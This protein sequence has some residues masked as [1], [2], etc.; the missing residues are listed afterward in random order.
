LPLKEGALVHSIPHLY[1]MVDTTG[2]GK[3]DSRTIWYTA[4]GFKDTHGMASAFTWGFDGWIYGCHGFSNTSTLQGLDGRPIRLT[5]GN[6]YR[7]RADGRHIESYSY[8]QVNP[9][10]LA[11][12][13][14]GN[15][16]S[17]DCHSRPVMMLLREGVYPSFGRPHDGLGFA[18]EIMTHDHGSTG[19]AGITYYAAT[20]FPEAY[21]DRIF[22]GN[23]VTSRINADRLEW[24][25]SSP[26]AIAEPDFLVSGDPWFRPVDIE[27]G[28]DGALYVA[29]FYNRIIGH[30][31]VDLLH[32]GRDRERG[33][34]WR[35]RYDGPEP[36]DPPAVPRHDWTVASPEQLADALDH[37]NPTIRTMAGNQLA[38]L[39]PDLARA[40]ARHAFE[41]ARTPSGRAQAMWALHR[42][43]A[44]T[45]DDLARATSDPDRLVRTH[46]MRAVAEVAEWTPVLSGLAIR[47]LVDPDAFV[48]RAAAETLGRHADAAAHLRPL[49]D[50]RHAASAADP[51]LVHTLRIALRNQLRDDPHAWTIVAGLPLSDADQMALTDVSPGVPSLESAR[52]VTA[53]LKRLAWPDHADWPRLITHVA[54]FGDAPLRD[55]LATWAASHAAGSPAERAG[56]VLAL[57]RGCDEAGVSWPESAQTWAE[58]LARSLLDSTAQADQEQGIDLSRTA[59][60]R[61]LLDRLDTLAADPSAQLLVR[62][63]ALTAQAEIDRSAALPR[64]S[65]VLRDGGTNPFVRERAAALLG[66]G[67]WPEARE[68]LIGALPVAPARLQ[69]AI[70]AALAADAD[71]AGALLAAIEAGKASPRVLLERNVATGLKRSK[72]DGVE[73][74][75]AALTADLPAPDAAIAAAIERRQASLKTRTGEVV[76]GQAVFTKTCAACHQIAGQGARIGPQLD[77]VGVRGADRLLEDLL[78]PSRNVD[79]A[80]RVTTVALAD[81]RIVTGLKL[82]EDGAAL[83]LADSQGQEVRLPTADIAEQAE[84]PL[85]L[86]P[87]NLGDQLSDEDLADLLAFLLS[88]KEAPVPA[89]N[90]PES[91]RHE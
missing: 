4:V 46:A 29:D 18:P 63:A 8:G 6:T 36:H 50:A 65:A 37:S 74:R 16:Y 5:S 21:R 44:L 66:T 88:R 62:N 76:R 68:A 81:G 56:L 78:D 84:V 90:A 15:L 32:P 14:L 61:A 35:I 19:I 41:S 49:L 80:F 83:V 71:G 31:E 39:S 22:I 57:R 24:S 75:L 28:P 3:A 25:G 7:L 40:A 23:V 87:A 10:G 54:R 86:M 48:R 77:G 2:D 67:G 33:R 82:R 69:P 42:L 59:R 45:P 30:Y 47:G 20:Q 9:F 58:S 13:P 55:E 43:D 89:T 17:C 70:A 34:I 51:Q 1:H 60:L 27:L 91:D 52:F 64:L 73:A 85:S 26:T 79:Q 72:L 11:F 12:D 38:W 53:H